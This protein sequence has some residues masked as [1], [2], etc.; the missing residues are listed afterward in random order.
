MKVTCHYR[1]DPERGL[2]DPLPEVGGRRFVLRI[3]SGDVCFPLLGT[4]FGEKWFE[5]P[6][7]RYVGQGGNHC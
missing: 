2:T 5:P 4:A 7:P 1:N 3:Y 6:F